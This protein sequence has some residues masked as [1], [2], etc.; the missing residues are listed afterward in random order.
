MPR[1]RDNLHGLL[2]G[3]R[4][5]PQI[6]LGRSTFVDDDGSE[7]ESGFDGS[8]AAAIQIVYTDS[9]GKRSERRV[10]CRKIIAN[11]WP[12][13]VMGYCHERQALRQFKI[14]S[15]EE[16]F[17]LSDGGVAV[18]VRAYFD[19]LHVDGILCR[20]D[21]LLCDFVRLLVFMARCDGHYHPMEEAALEYAVGRYFRNY[22]GSDADHETVMD[23]CRGLAPE[24][25]NVERA[26]R[27]IARSPERATLSRLALDSIGSV[28]DADGRHDPSEVE[29]A[30]AIT[31]EL[32]SCTAY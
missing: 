14:A 15:I 3:R 24:G 16:L 30:I 12:E 18:D 19:R 8:A 23:R 1:P 31:D 2:L 27:H 32:K 9:S 6:A 22:G 20:Q 17:D 11:G 5:T 4:V 29:W 7:I 13:Q 21:E 28:I 26:I 25:E 10:T